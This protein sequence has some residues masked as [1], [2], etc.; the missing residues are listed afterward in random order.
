MNGHQNFSSNF[1]RWKKRERH[2]TP[3]AKKFDVTRAKIPDVGE[4]L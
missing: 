2:Q 4:A 1:P 3:S